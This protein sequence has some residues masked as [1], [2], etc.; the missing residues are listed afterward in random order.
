MGRRLYLPWFSIPSVWS[1]TTTTGGGCRTADLRALKKNCNGSLAIDPPMDKDRLCEVT[2]AE[3]QASV[4]P[5]AL[6]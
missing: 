5:P 6:H 1:V 3:V 2:H 4:P